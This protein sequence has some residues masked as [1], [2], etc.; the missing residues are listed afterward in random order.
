MFFYFVMVSPQLYV[1]CCFKF[2]W[3]CYWWKNKILD[4]E[5][6]SLPAEENLHMMYLINNDNDSC[7]E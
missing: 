1:F 6:H 7:D 3:N 5:M 4:N 2:T